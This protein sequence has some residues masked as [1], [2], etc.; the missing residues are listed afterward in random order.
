MST[1]SS[2]LAQ[3]KRANEASVSRVEGLSE[4]FAKQVQDLDEAMDSL[5]DFE[6]INLR[7][8][9][10]TFKRQEDI[11]AFWALD[12]LLRY[13]PSKQMNDLTYVYPLPAQ[14]DLLALYK[15]AGASGYTI[16]E[17]KREVAVAEDGLPYVYPAFANQY[18]TMFDEE[19]QVDTLFLA[20]YFIPTFQQEAI[21]I[22]NSP[23]AKELILEKNP[24]DW[25][26]L[27]AALYDLRDNG[28]LPSSVV[29][30]M[31]DLAFSVGPSD[32]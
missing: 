19:G 25:L 31:I 24:K 16:F 28:S 14:V 7:F 11:D 4:N 27:I 29:E 2:N 32:G 9:V 12:S 22:L 13:L 10:V 23:N 17:I 5:S 18:D 30:A 20:S 21:D 6:K 26:V 1:F 8:Y 3:I 15:S